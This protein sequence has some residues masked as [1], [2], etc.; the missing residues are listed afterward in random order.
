MSELRHDPLSG[1]DVIVAAG[2]AARPVTFA[3]T[4]E[5]E[6]QAHGSPSCPF[7]PGAEAETPP[8]VARTGTGAP[9]TSG[10]RVRVFPNLY[11]IVDTHEVIA[12]SPSHDRS[13][14]HLDDDEVVEVFSVMRDRVR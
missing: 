4:R 6:P 8:E 3:P 14:A 10:W 12:L 9:G 5:P 11:P 2:R 13:M 7:C 1:H